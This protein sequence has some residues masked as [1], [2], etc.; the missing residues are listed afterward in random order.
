VHASL[1]TVHS[2]RKGETELRKQAFVIC[3]IVLSLSS[4][5]VVCA[6]TNQ[7]ATAV[8]D[9]TDNSSADHPQVDKEEPQSDPGTSVDTASKT[10]DVR[11]APGAAVGKPTPTAAA[12]APAAVSVYTFPSRTELTDYWLWNVVGPKAWFGGAFTASWKTWVDTS[13]TE[14]HRGADG[15]RKRFG[16]A[17]IDNS[18]NQSS[19]MLL[20][21]AMGQDPRYY[22]CACT[23][24]WPRTKHAF[25]MS[26]EGRNHNGDAVF[27]P[28]KIIAPFTGPV[29]THSTFYPARFGPSDGLSPY[30]LVG[31]VAW[32]FF[33]EF[34]GKSPSW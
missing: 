10:P 12:P 23:G 33:R 27:S 24:F 8:S 32:N 7:S 28:A 19:L 4:S 9:Q 21:S 15:W 31:G 25:K 1:A 30:Y 14:W 20:S 22:R 2:R 34:F 13:P 5:V 18:I 16:V 6:Q 11:T 17:L 3:L 26:F 29:V